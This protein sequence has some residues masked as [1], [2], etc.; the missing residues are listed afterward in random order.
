MG[1]SRIRTA[2]FNQP[3]KYSVPHDI[4]GKEFGRAE[5]GISQVVVSNFFCIIRYIHIYIYIY[6]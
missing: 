6:M 2:G 3:Q 4:K 5:L 1:G